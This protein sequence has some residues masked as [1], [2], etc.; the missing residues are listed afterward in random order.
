L[1]ADK[2]LGVG[3]RAIYDSIRKEVPFIEEDTMMKPLM[4]KVLE[5]VKNRNS[6]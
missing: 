5:L 3:T 6:I 4:D 1:G 2:K